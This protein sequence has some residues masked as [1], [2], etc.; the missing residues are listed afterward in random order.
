MTKR[1]QKKMRHLLDEGEAVQ[2]ALLVEPKGT[3]E[4]ASLALAALSRTTVR[5]LASKAQTEH[6]FY[7]GL[8]ASFSATS[9]LVVMTDRRLIIVPSHGISMKEIS[10]TY[11]CRDLFVAENTTKGPGLGG[12]C[13]DSGT[14]H[15]SRS[16][17]SG[18]N[19][20]ISL[21][22]C[23]VATNEYNHEVAKH[24]GDHGAVGFG[25]VVLRRRTSARH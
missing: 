9:C 7:G 23:L 2:S 1:V 6:E 24:R 8:A 21:P 18:V 14:A 22:R 20:L 11:D 15:R 16:T 19:R 10:A 3:F 4:V 17:L 25:R 5:R 12:W 13:F